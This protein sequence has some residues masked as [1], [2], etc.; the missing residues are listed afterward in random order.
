MM[1]MNKQDYNELDQLQKTIR[2]LTIL[3]NKTHVIISIAAE[4]AFY[5]SQHLFMINLQKVHI[6]EI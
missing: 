3:K 5:K 6:E 2:D 1:M 4:K